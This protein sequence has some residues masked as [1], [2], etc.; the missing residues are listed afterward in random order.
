MLV[1][2]CKKEFEDEY[3]GYEIIIKLE[4]IV[5]IQVNTDVAHRKCNLRKST[6]KE[7]PERNG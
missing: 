7:I 5:I 6:T 3:A 1:R 4:M 2:N